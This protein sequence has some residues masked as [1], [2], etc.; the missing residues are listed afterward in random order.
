[1][2]SSIPNL[3][4]I[5]PTVRPPIESTYKQSPLLYRLNVTWKE[6][7]MAHWR[8]CCHLHT[9]K[10]QTSWSSGSTAPVWASRLS[11]SER[12]CCCRSV[13]EALNSGP[14]VWSMSS[15]KK[16]LWIKSSRPDRGLGSGDQSAVQHT[17]RDSPP[18]WTRLGTMYKFT[19]RNK[20]FKEKSPCL[21]STTYILAGPARYDAATACCASRFLWNRAVMNQGSAHLVSKR[22]LLDPKIL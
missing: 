1:M 3:S 9:R 12:S 20:N 6:T 18:R 19:C 11:P 14:W 22:M 17:R 4:S 13:T 7:C 15:L 2:W 5:G 16:K 10:L 21:L 8:P